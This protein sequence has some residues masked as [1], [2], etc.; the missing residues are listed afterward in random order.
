MDWKYDISK[1]VN[2][3]PTPSEMTLLKLKFTIILQGQYKEMK[4]EREDA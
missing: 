2:K 3:K 1:G 4:D